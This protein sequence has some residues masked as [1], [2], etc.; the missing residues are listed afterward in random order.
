MY[1]H[2]IIVEISS[3]ITFDNGGE[4]N[5]LQ[6]TSPEV[7]T[8][9]LVKW[10]IHVCVHTHSSIINTLILI[11]CMI[12]SASSLEQRPKYSYRVFSKQP[13]YQIN[14]HS[15]S[16]QPLHSTWTCSG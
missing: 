2:V 8:V 15:G 14:V 10:Y 12:V 9:Q 1:L 3:R 16:A 7:N 6:C 5:T 13:C 11:S 4:W